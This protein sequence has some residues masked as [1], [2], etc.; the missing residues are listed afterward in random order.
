MKILLPIV[1]TLAGLGVGVGAG[2]K[3]RPEAEEPQDQAQ[4]SAQNPAQTP[5]A[6]AAEA[7]EPDPFA[8]VSLAREL[9]PG[10]VEFVALDK[11]F[12]IPVFEAERVAAMVVL[13]VSLEIGTGQAQSVQTFQPR[14]RDS[15]LAVMFRHANS[16]GF[17]GSFTAGQKM[18]DLKSALLATA[19]EIMSTAPV[20]EILITDIVRQD[21]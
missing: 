1:V 10:G 2:I 8:P 13:T 11:P 4:T 17:D 9:P 16:G 21:V 12:V 18:Q 6:P 15:F 5:P 19:R 14:L 20:T 3:L 7:A